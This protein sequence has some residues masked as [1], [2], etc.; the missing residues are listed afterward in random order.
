M[1]SS[2]SLKNRRQQFSDTCT[3]F[4]TLVAHCFGKSEDSSA[5]D[6]PF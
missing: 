3:V 6:E 4:G 2:V 1:E 5:S